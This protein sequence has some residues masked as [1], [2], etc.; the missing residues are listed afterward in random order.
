MGTV[1][2]NDLC[3]CGSGKKYKKCCLGSSGIPPVAKVDANA[4]DWGKQSR[5]RDQDNE[6][7][8]FIIQGY[9]LLDKQDHAGA[10]E[11]WGRVWDN[12][13]L[14][15]SPG[16]TSCE[17]TLSVYEGSFFL[18]NWIQDYCAALHNVALNNEATAKAGAS[19]CSQVLLQF[20][21]ESE[22]LQENFRASMGEF[23]YLAGA[24]AVGEKVLT[25]LIADRPHRAIGYAYMAD[26][27]GESKFNL[28]H[29]QPIDLPRAIHLLEQGLA[30]PVEDAEDYDLEKRLGWFR[31]TE[32]S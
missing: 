16:M 15:L 23:H 11:A 26:M 19:F 14:R 22:N 1:N 3:P 2:R 17:E 21:D 6:I 25:E 12:L 30:Y 18:V 28:G 5:G 13:L 20:P 29:D 8:R 24:P 31:E 10:S 4:E 7:D 27:V 32:K 9:D